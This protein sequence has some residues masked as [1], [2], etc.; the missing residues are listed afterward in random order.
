L[1]VTSLLLTHPLIFTDITPTNIYLYTIHISPFPKDTS[2]ARSRR[3]EC[4]TVY[5]EMAGVKYFG[6][7]KIIPNKDID[8]FSFLRK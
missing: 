7:S 4:F 3:R 1:K 8:T 6:D 5:K 2:I